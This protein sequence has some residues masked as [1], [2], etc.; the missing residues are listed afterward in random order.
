M[1]GPRGVS[2]K[3]EPS[4]KLLQFEIL[5][6]V[7]TNIDLDGQRLNKPELNPL[8][9]KK[10]EDLRTQI[11][12]NS[13]DVGRLLEYN[14][15]FLERTMMFA[16]RSTIVGKAWNSFFPLEKESSALRNTYNKA[17]HLK[18]PR[19]QLTFRTGNKMGLDQYAYC[20]DKFGDREEI[21]YWRQHNR[22]HGWMEELYHNNGGDE[23][24]NCI[25]LELTWEDIYTLE[26]AIDEQSLPPTSGF[27]FGQDSY[28]D[29]SKEDGN[30]SKDIKFLERARKELSAGNK[31]YYHAW[32]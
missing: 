14:Q 12:L 16:M 26:D 20:E 25:D 30:N 11:E 28:Q 3:K 7:E 29:Y 27:F 8:K 21:A 4:A 22:L 6:H 1:Q 5:Y 15:E 9:P 18:L 23:E 17:H 19:N 24:F 32:W 2:I 10:M 31:V 13:A